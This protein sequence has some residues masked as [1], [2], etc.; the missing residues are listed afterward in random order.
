M[1]SIGNLSQSERAAYRPVVLPGVGTLSVKRIGAEMSGDKIQAPVNVV[2]FTPHEQAG[3]NIIVV[4]QSIGLSHE[5]AR[6]S[7]DQWLEQMRSGDSII[8]E[9]VRVLSGSEFRAD[10]QM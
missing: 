7:Y 9:S 3:E 4:M 5:E 8:I 1:K 6:S 10:P 2:D